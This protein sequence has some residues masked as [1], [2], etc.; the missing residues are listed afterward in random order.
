MRPLKQGLDYFPFDVDFFGDKKVKVVKA[1]YGCDGM[2]VFIYLLCQ[3]Y[4]N[5]YYIKLDEDYEYIISDEL[6]MEPEK[7][8]QII[9]FLCGRSLFENKLFASD[10]V[11]TS[12]GIQ[13]RFQEAIK[14]RGTKRVIEVDAKIW[15]LSDNET[16]SYIKVTH[17]QGF[18]EK[19]PSKSEKNE[20][21]SAEEV[22]KENKKEKES[23]LKENK[24]IA[25]VVASYEKNISSI[26]P[27]V[28]EKIEMWLKEVD[29]SLVIYAI[30]QAVLKN[31]KSWSYINGVINN[32]YKSG[33]KNRVDAENKAQQKKTDGK[34]V[35]ELD[36]MAAVERKMRLE[37]MNTN[38]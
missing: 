27:I 18:F 25:V 2:I 22:H 34:G 33:K 3:I 11:L 31:K 24:D 26:S 6:R 37:R 15:L 5:G 17:F 38:A 21:F 1:K 23:K 9:N 19:N 8:G 35:Y 13:A 7:I 28:S 36:D 30:E 32:C 10:K 16:E 12:R 4:I 14:K 29:S 20:G